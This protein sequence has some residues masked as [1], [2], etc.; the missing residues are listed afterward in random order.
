VVVRRISGN[1]ERNI[2]AAVGIEVLR[3]RRW[4]NETGKRCRRMKVGCCALL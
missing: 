1:G 3:E 2:A 4:A